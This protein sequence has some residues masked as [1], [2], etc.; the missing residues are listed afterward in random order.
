MDYV[1]RQTQIHFGTKEAD[2]SLEKVDRDFRG[3]T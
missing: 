2:S 1:G 3:H